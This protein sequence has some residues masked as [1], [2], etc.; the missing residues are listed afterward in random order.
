MTERSQDFP[1]PVC[2]AASW[3]VRIAFV[4]LT[5]FAILTV[6][7][8]THLDW[9]MMRLCPS[10]ALVHGLNIYPGLDQ[11]VVTGHIYGPLSAMFYA[12]L[13]WLGDVTWMVRAASLITM[14]VFGLPFFLL[15]QRAVH[16]GLRTRTE[17]GGLL[18][19]VLLV[20]AL[21]PSLRYAAVMVH[22]EGPAVS[23]GLLAIILAA[24]GSADRPDLF[25][26]AGSCAAAAIF[27]KQTQ[28]VAWAAL[29]L[30]GTLINGR[31]WLGRYVLGSLL[32]ASV[33]CLGSLKWTTL[34]AMFFNCVW[35]P[36]HHP[37]NVASF[38]FSHGH[39]PA[40]PTLSERLRALTEA[41]TTFAPLWW[42][43]WAAA[44]WTLCCH[45]PG[46]WRE[47]DFVVRTAYYSATV[48]LFQ[49]PLALAGF[50]K[51][52]GGINSLAVTTAPGL[53]LLF[54]LALRRTPPLP[55]SSA[56]RLLLAT[57]LVTLMG[58]NLPRLGHLAHASWM[59]ADPHRP[60]MAYLREHPGEVYLPWNPLLTLQADHQ[61][62]HFEYG[63]F[64][65][66]LA[67]APISLAH[68]RSGL[69]G[70]LR[71]VAVPV[72]QPD[73]S[74]G[75]YLHYFG[76]LKQITSP[77]GLEKWTF[78]EVPPDFVTSAHALHRSPSEL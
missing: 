71:V 74:H 35:I 7:Y 73:Q 32:A 3:S 56:Y 2:G 40:L 18:A 8:S 52:G 41:F 23:L 55:Q 62:Y 68:H 49:I 76:P 28:A 37:W 39:T 45:A 36:S 25:F 22:A 26:W 30:A 78:L 21:E 12:P 17:A 1:D 66:A 38:S 6:L 10:V 20:I 16:H 29:G 70:N 64:D 59:R 42:P 77:P 50:Q 53:L 47:A 46:R 44:V 19:V 58:C 51:I 27:T 61:L 65:R 33:I 48:A 43:A 11:G 5:G 67:G 69:P 31:Q 34:Q 15:G 14:L 9:N 57:G 13:A 60:M 63:I 75:T 54:A 72:G 4:F 24:W